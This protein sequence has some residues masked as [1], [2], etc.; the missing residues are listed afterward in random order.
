MGMFRQGFAMGLAGR[1]GSPFGLNEVAAL[2]HSA[3]GTDKAYKA[4]L[5]RSGVQGTATPETPLVD[6]KAIKAYFAKN[7]KKITYAG[8]GLTAIAAGGFKIYGDNMDMNAT[9]DQAMCGMNRATMVDM[10]Q[11]E[12]AKA[13]DFYWRG[14]RAHSYAKQDLRTV[15]AKGDHKGGAY[16]D[17][18]RV[19]ACIS[20]PVAKHADVDRVAVGVANYDA[21]T[22]ELLQM[23]KGDPAQQL[24]QLRNQARALELEAQHA[25]QH[26]RLFE[27]TDISRTN[28]VPLT[29]K[30]HVLEMYAYQIKT[31]PGGELKSGIDYDSM[32]KDLDSS[33]ALHDAG[34][35]DGTMQMER[36]AAQEAK[37]AAFMDGIQQTQKNMTQQIANMAIH[38]GVAKYLQ[39]QVKLP[40]DGTGSSTNLRLEDFDLNM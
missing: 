35:K 11:K 23:H 38:N 10:L 28:G 39:D 27:T 22:Y 29:M 20:V 13:P 30:A 25:E 19:N 17:A 37:Q 12:A 31:N 6:T 36:G 16:T 4:G 2:Y 14:A 34:Y 21:Q 26:D 32:V 40:G 15:D 24:Y 33:Y 5:E 8:L 1:G 18:H 3:E 7:W 9:F